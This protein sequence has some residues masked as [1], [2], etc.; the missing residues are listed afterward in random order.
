MALGV[1]EARYLKVEL[2]IEVVGLYL[3]QLLLVLL[4]VH[5]FRRLHEDEREPAHAAFLLH[6]EHIGGSHADVCLHMVGIYGESLAEAPARFGIFF[7]VE[8]YHALGKPCVGV[9]AVLLYEPLHLLGGKVGLIAVGV[10]VNE[11]TQELRV[12]RTLL[13]RLVEQLHAQVFE[14]LLLASLHAGDIDV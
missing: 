7:L 2:R 12:V 14:S 4:L 3:S 10:M 11:H 6:V 8:E 9:V 13:H 1:V 5:L